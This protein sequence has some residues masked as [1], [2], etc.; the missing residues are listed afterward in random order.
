MSVLKGDRKFWPP[1]LIS[2][3]FTIF[4]FG[5]SYTAINL[6]IGWVD[7]GFGIAFLAVGLC[8]ARKI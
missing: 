5:V 8:M 4:F 7:I 1:I 2:S 3:G 6:A